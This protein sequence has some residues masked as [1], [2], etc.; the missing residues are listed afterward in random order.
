MPRLMPHQAL[1][2]LSS[3]MTHTNRFP[4]QF[5]LFLV[6]VEQIFL[7]WSH[8]CDRYVKNASMLARKTVGTYV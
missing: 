8:S 2:A 1:L 4:W 5:L 6:K 3:A 7:R